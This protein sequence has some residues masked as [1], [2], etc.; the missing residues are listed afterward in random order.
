MQTTTILPTNETTTKLGEVVCDGDGCWN[1]ASGFDGD[2]VAFVCSE[3]ESQDTTN[4]TITYARKTIT[5]PPDPDLDEYCPSIPALHT[6][7]MAV[8][9]GTGL[10]YIDEA[11]DGDSCYTVVHL[12]SGKF[13]N[14][15]WFV[16]TER[17]AQLWIDW[18]VRFAD[19]TGLLPRIRDKQLFEVFALVS[20]GMLI[21]P[22]FDPE[23]PGFDPS[24]VQFAPADAV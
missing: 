21:D 20:A 5:L 9:E 7:E 6:Y 10:A 1:K 13:L 11:I 4:H 23:H 14:V 18:L 24:T 12:P 16:E 3:H 19:W 15:G 8:A 17:L 22:T 2:Q